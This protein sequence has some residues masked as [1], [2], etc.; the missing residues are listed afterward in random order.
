MMNDG[1]DGV[2]DVMLFVGD[3]MN[4]IHTLYIDKYMVLRKK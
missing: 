3:M 1:D 4:N 2:L